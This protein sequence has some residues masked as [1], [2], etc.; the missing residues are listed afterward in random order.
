MTFFKQRNSKTFKENGKLWTGVQQQASL[1]IFHSRVFQK[2][3][4]CLTE[5]LIMQSSAEKIILKM[6]HD[7]NKLTITIVL[8]NFPNFHSILNCFGNVSK[9]LGEGTGS[10]LLLIGQSEVVH[11]LVLNLR[12]K[13]NG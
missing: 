4:S 9:E 6:K 12:S 13:L 5:L 8:S 3:L 2:V 10:I 7:F 1:C 11:N